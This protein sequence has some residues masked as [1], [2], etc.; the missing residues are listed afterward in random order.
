MKQK[1]TLTEERNRMLKLINFNYD[2]HSHDILSTKLIK[3]S[4][5]HFWT[6][7][8][9]TLFNEEVL[10]SSRLIKENDALLREEEDIDVEAEFATPE[11]GEAFLNFV[12]DYLTKLTDIDFTD[13]SIEE[14]YSTDSN[15]L[16]E[17][18]KWR[19]F[20][21]K[22]GRKF[23]RF[24]DKLKYE[25][26]DGGGKR[27]MK[28][29]LRNFKKSLEKAGKNIGDWFGDTMRTL[30]KKWKGLSKDIKGGFK[31][32]GKAIGKAGR[33]LRR[34]VPIRI[35]KYKP[36]ESADMTSS[37]EFTIKTEES[38]W[39]TM[40]DSKAA[41]KMVSLMNGSSKSDWESLKN[42]EENK[43][44]AVAAV[45]YFAET[46]KEKKWKSVGVGMDI[47]ELINVIPDDDK[48]E[49]GD[50]KQFPI[51]P[52]DFPSTISGNDLFLNNKWTVDGAPGLEKEVN[53][54][55]KKLK[56]ELKDLKPPEGKPKATLNGIYLTSSC[57][58]FRNNVK[59]KNMTFK[60][61][62]EKRA[63]TVRDYIIA[64]LSEIGIQKND[65]Y[66]ESI[67]ATGTNGD[68]SSGPNPPAGSNGFAYI[69]VGS[70][71]KMSPACLKNQNECEINGK[72]VK[73]NEAGEPF[74]L[75]EAYD[76]FKY[77]AGDID[78]VLNTSE[79]GGGGSTPDDDTNVEPNVEIIDVKEYP[80]SF[81]APPKNPLEFKFKINLPRFR[82]R[83]KV[84]YKAPKR[85]KRQHSTSCPAFN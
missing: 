6:E 19:R 57:S 14:S 17:Q 60:E 27:K 24:K 11:E 72:I 2:E 47:E 80:I 84:S 34:G 71:I 31:K 43:G 38:E 62:A 85:S 22:L 70:G 68:G 58:R 7:E 76:K 39:D 53:A 75:K 52:I 73:R 29:K 55:I 48:E 36:S 64:R 63:T 67:D 4:T 56:E 59:P 83:S 26:F 10:Y 69:P 25:V 37:D 5:N 40:L 15:L 32:M 46:Y 50:D 78:I 3:E 81:Y 21:K 74:P 61:L 82:R 18:A 9:A 54:L 30:K 45:E 23:R 49:E 13:D 41:K 77:V 8:S 79:D 35:G 65:G 16:T 51:L 12:E 44:F 42:D 1:L 33:K 66:S 20:K 28:K